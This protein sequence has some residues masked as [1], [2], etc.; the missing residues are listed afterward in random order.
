M[1]RKLYTSAT[2]IVCAIIVALTTYIL[3]IRDNTKP[4]Y[5]VISEVYSE[6]QHTAVISDGEYLYDYDYNTGLRDKK[7]LARVANTE[8][9]LS[10]LNSSRDTDIIPIPDFPATYDC[11]QEAASWYINKLLSGGYSIVEY[12]TDS[13][14]ID[15]KLTDR[16]Y[17]IRVV[18]IKDSY[19]YIFCVDSGK[20]YTTPPYI[21]G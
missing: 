8:S 16:D 12:E 13:T 1:R 17:V 20:N 10:L 6:T 3:F 9:S 7:R 15:Y 19:C 18:W 2:I 21:N 5:Y 14:H 4:A 11:T